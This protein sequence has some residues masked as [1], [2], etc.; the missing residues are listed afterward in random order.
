M[1]NGR[2]WRGPR[3]LLNVRLDE[4][5]VDLEA[6]EVPDINLGFGLPFRGRPPGD[7]L[8]GFAPVLFLVPLG[9][10]ELAPSRRDALLFIRME[11]RSGLL[12]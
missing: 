6:Y 4:E 9:F 2:S 7:N 1:L 8:G 10:P 5:D 11:M 12:R 3:S